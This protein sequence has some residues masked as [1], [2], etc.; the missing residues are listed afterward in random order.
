[1]VANLNATNPWDA[2]NEMVASGQYVY[3]S[4][5]EPD[6][7]QLDLWRTDGT[8]AGT[9][10]LAGLGRYDGKSRQLTD[11]DGDLYFRGHS[12]EHG[13]ELWKSDG[14][15][16]GT[17]LLRDLTPGPGSSLFTSPTSHRGRV[18]FASNGHLMRSNGTTA[19]TVR[20]VDLVPGASDEV[21][22]VVR[23][24]NRVYFTAGRRQDSTLYTT[25]GTVIGTVP[26]PGAPQGRLEPLQDVN[27][28]L[29][30][31]H[32]GVSLWKTNGTSAGTRLMVDLSGGGQDPY[33]LTDVNGTLFF[34]SFGELWKT[35]GTTT[36]TVRLADTQGA[37]SGL[38]NAEGT[39]YFSGG[40]ELNGEGY[41]PW[42]SDGTVA[43]TFMLKDIR[44]GFDEGYSHSSHPHSFT[45]WNGRLYF[46]ADGNV[47]TSD[48]T[49]LGTQFFESAL[50][51]GRLVQHQNQLFFSAGMRVFKR[52]VAAATSVALDR[53]GPG[54]GDSN[55]TAVA[56][57]N[58]TLY[59]GASDGEVGDELWKHDPV[60]QVTSLVKDIVPGPG[61]LRV[62]NVSAFG[63]SLYFTAGSELWVSDGTEAG[64][65]PLAT[66]DRGHSL[67]I[68][69]KLF[70]AGGDRN[71][72]ELWVTDGTA[73]GTMMVK[74][75]APGGRYYQGAGFYPNSSYPGEF[76]SFQ[77][78]LYF[79]ATGPDGR[80]LWKSDGTEAGTVE[81]V[82]FFP[83]YGP[84]YESSPAGLTNFNGLL[85]FAATKDNRRGLW[86]SDGTAEGTQL[87]TNRAGS[88]TSLQMVNN[89]L[90]FAA[91]ASQ[92][93]QEL[94]K[95]DGTGAGTKMV[96]D[97][98]AGSRSS[99]IGAL[100]AAEGMLYFAAD[101]G[102]HGRELWRSDG[103]ATGTRLVRDI[104]AGFDA[105]N[106]ALGSDPEGLVFLNGVL[107][108]T[109]DDGRSGRELW[110]TN[111]TAPGATRVNDIQPGQEGSGSTDLVVA[112]QAVYF[113]AETE[114]GR[115]LWRAASLSPVLPVFSAPLTYREDEPPL[116]LAQDGVPVD[117]DT[118]PLMG[119]ELTVSFTTPP[120]AGD[121]LLVA[122]RGG[123]ETTG[124][125]VLYNGTVIGRFSGGANGTSLRIALNA[126]VGDIALMK[127]FQALAFRSI[128]QHPS[129]ARRRIR[130]DL[131]D[132]E[133][134]AAKSRYV[135]VDVQRI[136]DAPVIGNLGGSIRY[137]INSPAG[138]LVAGEA[139]VSDV[140]SSTFR[141][142]ELIVSVRGGDA[143]NNLL[144][145]VGSVFTIDADLNLLRR[146]VIIG[147]VNASGGVRRIPLSFQFNEHARPSVVQEL[148]RSIKFRTL[149]STD[150][151]VRVVTVRLTDGDGGRVSQSRTIGVV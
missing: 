77:G 137:P 12:A 39:L 82:D 103:T 140:D 27:G 26:V 43:G 113:S 146:G 131:R 90:F 69:D 66:V 14:T 18:F 148:L 133:G 120:R 115:E 84:Y 67:E 31:S 54:S 63:G 94:W 52:D 41:E 118:E 74:N 78:Q 6:S 40:S 33:E 34:A 86:K 50:F 55:P 112:G 2:I 28:E 127:L 10:R 16:A 119:G 48:G 123:V 56:E 130:F 20:V 53:G 76:T 81:V 139:T 21:T 24:G 117:P 111:G 44:P 60:S 85:Y 142:G 91:S 49:E 83:D 23:A 149:A 151:G 126:N 145:L 138:V 108:F 98:R 37:I 88:P 95:S 45:R 141:R 57:L 114:A 116:I 30:F 71:G 147:R 129:E 22:K 61:S 143:V 109:A 101:D 47:W 97:I 122:H 72:R 42:R 104:R 150:F 125:W 135:S 102:V 15:V 79:S 5:S 38:F 4:A 80:E 70:F 46:V 124:P 8:Q 87:V 92:S 19:G 36:G 1:M 51:S 3:F 59:F 100:F 107:F 7:D 136:N 134:G 68:G 144:Y 132:G 128:S 17:V 11:V 65:V 93:G 121:E 110:R 105:N 99:G 73:A 13:D 58:G 106:S 96:K 62:R 89:Q 25:N 35:D 9:I 29:Y 75:I 32:N 64:T